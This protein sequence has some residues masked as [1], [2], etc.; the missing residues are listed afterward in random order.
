MPTP[1]GRNQLSSHRP[2]PREYVPGPRIWMRW[3]TAVN[4]ILYVLR[5]GIP[6]RKR[7]TSAGLG[8]PADVSRRNLDSGSGPV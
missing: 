2:T 3:S 1:G 8:V 4:G 6:C 7:P 5:G